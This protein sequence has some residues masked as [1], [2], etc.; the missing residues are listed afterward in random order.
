MAKAKNANPG[1]QKRG[2]R[3]SRKPKKASAKVAKPNRSTGRVFN[4][5]SVVRGAAQQRAAIAKQSG[6]AALCAI[7]D[8]FCKHAVGA[9]LPDGSPGNSLTSSARGFVTM[10]TSA[11][12]GYSGFWFNPNNAG[13][14]TYTSTTAS[15][16]QAL[17]AAWA[18]VAGLSML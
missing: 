8:P 7:T 12:A 3:K 9:K 10:V 13:Y 4:N 6:T 18:S 2:S 14:S 5:S 11:S 15:N 1:K 17:G 16:T